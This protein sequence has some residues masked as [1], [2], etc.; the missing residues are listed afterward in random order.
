MD[1]QPATTKRQ[2][3][4]S[5]GRPHSYSKL[6]YKQAVLSTLAYFDV[7][8]YP[9]TQEET[10][11]YLFQIEPDAHHIEIT[12]N[13]SQ[14]I[15]KRGSYYQL[16][17]ENNHIAT[18]HE[19]ALVAKRLWKRVERFR[20]LFETIPYIKL[21]AICN[22][23]ALSNT[24]PGSDIDL[25]IVTK[26]GR[27]FIT[28]LILTCWLHL[29]GVRRHGEKISERFCLSFFATEEA[30]NFEYLR[31]GPVDIYL[32]YWLQTIKPICGERETYH[33]LLH[34][35]EAWLNKI[36]AHPVHPNIHRFKES[37]LWT[38]SLKRL[39]EKILDTKWGEKL[40]SKLEHWQIKR[41]EKK[42]AQIEQANPNH[43]IIINKHMLKFHNIDRRETFYQKWIDKLQE[44]L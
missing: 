33:A 13:E 16:I 2:Q 41:A 38:K 42:K 25:F 23:L 6:N 43:G 39:Q 30:L 9:L 31:R 26:P 5:I 35:N 4:K 28:R 21:V 12:L 18:R 32:A 27:L 40:E 24:K 10:K 17:G 1:P 19:R 14:F 3:H 22:N 8:Q 37:S 11:R 44:V 34:E 20:L 15:K 7:S 29:F 36:F